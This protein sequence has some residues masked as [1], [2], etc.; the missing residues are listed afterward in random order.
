LTLDETNS[1]I[2]VMIEDDGNYTF[3]VR[4]MDDDGGMTFKEI[5]IFANN[6]VPRADVSFEGLGP[7]GTIDQGKW[8]TIDVNTSDVEADTISITWNYPNSNTIEVEENSTN[9]KIR[10]LDAGNYPLSFLLSDED[11]G[12]LIWN[13]TM[14]VE[15]DYYFDNDGDGLPRWYEIEHDLDDGDPD[16][17]SED[18]DLDGLSNLAEFE[19]GTE[20]D[21]V[22]SDG[23]GMPDAFEVEH[24]G[25]DPNTDDADG[26]L[27][28]DGI[29]NIQEFEN[30]TDPTVAKDK[31]DE[32]GDNTL[33]FI[34]LIVIGLLLAIG[35]I[36]LMIS[37]RR[38]SSVEFY[39]EE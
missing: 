27:D 35:T 8:L 24:D 12:E 2:E 29:T 36:A 25:L 14:Q 11:G 18:N 33:L 31:D 22:D 20:P 10:S 9:L 39:D 32:N 23:D 16:D 30:G 34:L 28:G 38:D 19:N 15:E 3:Q 37:R 5:I 1:T 21:D 17:A 6:T 26:D 4:I 13:W 7:L